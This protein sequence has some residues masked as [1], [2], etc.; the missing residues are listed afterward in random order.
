MAADVRLYF[1]LK[2]T[3]Y[4]FDCIFCRVYFV[5]YVLSVYI[6]SGIFCP[7]IFYL[8]IIDA[9]EQRSAAHYL[10]C[11]AHASQIYN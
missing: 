10:S 2:Y 3:G 8:W 5:R 4:I 6:L 1:K 9:N 7:G 11:T